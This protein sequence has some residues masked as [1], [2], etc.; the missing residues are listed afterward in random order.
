VLRNLALAA[1]ALASALPVAER[2]LGWLDGVTGLG[3][4]A[5]GAVLFAAADALRARPVLR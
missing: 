3:A 2:A 5:C 1:A 4:L